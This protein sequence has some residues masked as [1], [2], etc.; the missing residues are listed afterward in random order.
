MKR[1]QLKGF[2]SNVSNKYN[3]RMISEA[4]KQM[5]HKRIDNARGVL[6]EYINYYEKKSATM[7]GSGIR[8]KQRGGNVIFFNDAKQLLCI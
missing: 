7:K 4:E 2:K 3:S 6:N 8:S 5:L 1:N